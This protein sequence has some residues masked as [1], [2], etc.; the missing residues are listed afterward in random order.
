[1][2]LKLAVMIARDPIIFSEVVVGCENSRTAPKIVTAEMAL[3]IDI[4]GVCRSGG[5]LE[6]SR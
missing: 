1:M 5:T 4:K 2:T 3:V 6:I